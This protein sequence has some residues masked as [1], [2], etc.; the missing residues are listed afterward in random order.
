MIVVALTAAYLYIDYYLFYRIWGYE[1][2]EN[3]LKAVLLPSWFK[4]LLWSPVVFFGVWLI[5]K[6]TGPFRQL[7]IEEQAEGVDRI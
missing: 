5:D 2:I 4:T 3:V 7:V 1:G 6:L